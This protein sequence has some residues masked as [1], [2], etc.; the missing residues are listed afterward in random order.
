MKSEVVLERTLSQK[1]TFFG[2]AEADKEYEVFRI[3]LLL[4]SLCT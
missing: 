4:F 1:T 3:K 2:Y